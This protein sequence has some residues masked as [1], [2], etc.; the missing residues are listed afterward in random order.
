MEPAARDEVRSSA[1]AAPTR[2][3]GEESRLAVCRTTRERGGRTRASPRSPGAGDAGASGGAS[4][5]LSGNRRGS[6]ARPQPHV[7]PG[8]RPLELRGG[9]GDHA[10]GAPSASTRAGR[11]RRERLDRGPAAPDRGGAGIS[12]PSGLHAPQAAAGTSRPPAAT[13][14]VVARVRSPSSPGSRDPARSRDSAAAVPALERPPG[15]RR[16]AGDG[17]EAGAGTRGRKGRPGG[18]P[19]A[20]GGY[21]GVGL[22]APDRPAPGQH[23]LRSCGAHAAATPPP[24]APATHAR[25]NKTSCGS[26]LP[27]GAG[28]VTHPHPAQRAQV[29][30]PRGQGRP[31]DHE[32]QEAAHH[33]QTA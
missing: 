18:G 23:H 31:E 29:V 9:R 20:A 26:P 4:L 3:G 12:P 24:L 30:G 10:G 1:R 5:P 19:A 8:S 22:G 15:R 13:A 7:P 2:A 28:R 17:A 27:E 21:R 32:P 14:G 33:Q 25:A 16:S 11:G 6:R